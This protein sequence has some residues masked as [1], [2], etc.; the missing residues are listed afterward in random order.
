[1]F[2]NGWASEARGKTCFLLA[3]RK[4]CPL[5]MPSTECLLLTPQTTFWLMDTVVTW[6]AQGSFWFGCPA[7]ECSLW[8]GLLLTS[9]ATSLW[10]V[11]ILSPTCPFSSSL[12]WSPLFFLHFYHNL[13]RPFLRGI[14]EKTKRFFGFFCFCFCSLLRYHAE[15]HNER[16]NHFFCLKWTLYYSVDQFQG[17]KSKGKGFKG[18]GDIRIRAPF[19]LFLFAFLNVTVKE[20]CW[21]QSSSCSLLR[22]LNGLDFSQDDKWLEGPSDWMCLAVTGYPTP[23]G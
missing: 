15:M 23:V 17:F 20:T 3:L 22:S 5:L 13:H 8:L 1:M 12:Y 19:L 21:R 6:T 14:F 2:R 7:L 10:N 11:C 4:G 16:A 9:T 18:E